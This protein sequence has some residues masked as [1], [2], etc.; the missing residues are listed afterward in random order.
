MPPVPLP[1]ITN[2]STKTPVVTDSHAPA[3]DTHRVQQGDT[4]VSLA[5]SYYGSARYAKFLKDANPAI[6]DGAQLTPGAAI[7]I[8]PLP[9]DL[10][11][12]ASKDATV[13][14][15]DG[16]AAKNAVVTKGGKRTYTAKSGDSLYKIA[17]DQL[18]SSSRWK[19]VFELNKAA[20]HNDPTQLRIGQTIV[21]PET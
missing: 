3:V 14:K 1:T 9:N 7:K 6:P 12:S 17:K 8:P 11:K 20:L 4:F 19:D 2:P 13:N 10:D 21:L 15:T 5:K 16:A 18:G